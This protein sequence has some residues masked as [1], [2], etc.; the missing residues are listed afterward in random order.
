MAAALK[1][2]NNAILCGAE[3]SDI[4]SRRRCCAPGAAPSATTAPQPNRTSAGVSDVGIHA[5]SV[6]TANA[7]EFTGPAG[8]C[9][10]RT[11]ARGWFL[12]VPRAGSSAR[13]TRHRKSAWKPPRLPGSTG[14]RSLSPT[15][16]RCV[17][18]DR[19]REIGVS[20]LGGAGAL[21][22]EYTLRVCLPSRSDRGENSTIEPTNPTR[23]SIRPRAKTTRCLPCSKSASHGRTGGSSAQEFAGSHGCQL[24][25][26]ELG[27]HSNV[28]PN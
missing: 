14:F 19:R 23:L 22:R 4:R 13:S 24:A 5:V 11:L 3:Y 9:R 20:R 16:Q 17:R 1:P 26:V 7:L 2:A 6:Q 21:H 15:A 28:P 18:L 25:R 12:E 10:S 8:Y 27:S